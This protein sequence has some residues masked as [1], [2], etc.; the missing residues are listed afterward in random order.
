ML[1]NFAQFYVYCFLC[2]VN[3]KVCPTCASE[4]RVYNK[5]YQKMSRNNLS[6]LILEF[7]K[8][9]KSITLNTEKT[10]LQLLFLG[11]FS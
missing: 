3:D 2:K 5:V 7:S 11:S 9:K 8:G 1:K 6:L 4:K 10:H